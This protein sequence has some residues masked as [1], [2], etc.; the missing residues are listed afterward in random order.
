MCIS[1][2]EVILTTWR[3]P[4]WRQEVWLASPA[5]VNVV[6]LLL[7]KYGLRVKM[8]HQERLCVLLSLQLDAL[9][10]GGKR[11]CLPLQLWRFSHY[12]TPPFTPQI[13][14][15]RLFDELLSECFT[16]DQYYKTLFR[17]KSKSNCLNLLV[18]R[19]IDDVQNIDFT[20]K[21]QIYAG[22]FCLATAN[23]HFFS[24]LLQKSTMEAG[25]LR[26]AF[27]VSQLFA[28]LKEESHMALLT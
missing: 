1:R 21:F 8:K 23:R 12:L 15:K 18:G 27:S 2:R 24:F 17:K 5:S 19:M 11:S 10:S 3:P 20:N 4:E 7:P 25:V 9:L 26:C 28:S 13:C 6:L 22:N 16:Q 14:A